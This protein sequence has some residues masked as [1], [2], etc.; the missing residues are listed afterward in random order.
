MKSMMKI[1][2]LLVVVIASAACATKAGVE[3]RI[4]EIRHSLQEGMTRAE[5]EE[6]YESC[7]I[8][9][10][11]RT[12]EDDR[13]TIP[14]FPWKAQDAVGYYGG[15]IRDVRT[16]YWALASEH[17]TIDVEIDSKDR[18]SQVLVGKSY[19]AP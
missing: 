2:C 18:V 3:M 6:F 11:F 16:I 17:I 15:I 5:V 19:T 12:R 4:R 9:Y 1:L 7:R 8:P 13:W 10:S 14:K